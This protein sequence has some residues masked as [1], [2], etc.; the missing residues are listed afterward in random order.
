MTLLSTVRPFASRLVSGGYVLV[1]QDFMINIVKR[2][3][4]IKRK[5]TNIEKGYNLG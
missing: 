1:P 3:G 5:V 4:I 2:L